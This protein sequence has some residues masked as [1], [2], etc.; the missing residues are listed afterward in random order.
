[1]KRRKNT[2]RDTC[3]GVLV[4]YP[5]RTSAEIASYLGV[6]RHVPSRLLAELR[7]RGQV[8]MGYKRL[9]TITGRKCLTWYPDDSQEGGGV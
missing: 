7:Y 9:C 1:M 6:E 2:M 8:V 5:G 4:S 3:L